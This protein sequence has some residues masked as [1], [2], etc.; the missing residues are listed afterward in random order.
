[1][2]ENRIIFHVDVNSAFLSWSAVKR[3]KEDPEV[4]DIRTV[5]AVICGD[6]E[7]RHGI[8]TAK[9]IPAK[10]YGIETAEPVVSAMRKC[11]NLLLVKGDRETYKHYS[12]AFI[13]ILHKYGPVVQQVSIDEAYMDMTGTQE[14]FK[15]LVTEDL[16]FPICVADAIKAEIRDTLGFTVNV[17]ISSN[18]L[19]AKMASDFKKPDRIHTL[20]PS[21]V[22]E[23][24]W[25]LPIGELHGCGKQSAQ[26]LNRLGFFT[27]G[28]VAQMDRELLQMQMGEKSGAYLW[29]S[30]NGISDS[31]VHAERDEVKS[32]SNE[33]TLSADI[34]RNNYE[35]EAADVIR[36]LSDSVARRLRKKGIFGGTVFISVKN[37]AFKR[38]SRQATLDTSTD[39]SEVIFQNAMM[40]LDQ[41]VWGNHGL[42]EKDERIRLL[43]VGVSNLDHGEY[44][45]MS[46]FDMMTD[47][48][49]VKSEKAKESHSFQE[50]TSTYN[51][52]CDQEKAK[53]LNEALDQIKTKFGDRSIVRGSHLKRK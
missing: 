16:P 23:K 52:T 42:F 12:D 4:L 6:V 19:L 51:N 28:D 40:L 13:Q 37:S 53:R 30:A 26:K 1:M 27:I 29:R 46:L 43:G 3:L 38:Y 9:S 33:T 49:A 18:K 45:Q 32:V 22:P 50:M 7:S 31:P 21:E 15:H 36:M 35:K 5:P 34:T 2:S 47:Y 44:R 11:P 41:L 14:I 17:G 24:M 48:G 25:P 39:T 10:A 20:W 8:V